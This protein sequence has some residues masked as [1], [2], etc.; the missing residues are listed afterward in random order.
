[1]A[2]MES[3]TELNSMIACA[4]ECT[5]QSRWKEQ[6]QRYLANLLLN[7]VH[8]RDELRDGTY[9]VKPTKDFYLNERGH[10]RAPRSPASGSRYSCAAI[11]ASTARTAISC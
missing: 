5:R 10:I 1:M 4:W 7:S 2:T 6:T 8:L 9:R 11:S 3:L